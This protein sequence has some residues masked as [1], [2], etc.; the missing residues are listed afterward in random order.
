MPFIHVKTNQTVSPEKAVQLKAALGEAITLIP[1]KTEQWLMVQIEDQNQLWLAGSDA[2]A[3]FADVRLVGSAS[4][5]DYTRLTERLT[6]LLS[7]VLEVA[8]DRVY[9][10]YQEIGHWGWNYRNF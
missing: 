8:P 3:A 6:E 4:D 9:I 10:P 2:P 7:E 5:A 1:G